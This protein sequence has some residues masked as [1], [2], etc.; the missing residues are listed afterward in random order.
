[1]DSD[2][3][4]GGVSAEP[5]GPPIAVEGDT[6]EGPPPGLPAAADADATSLDTADGAPS[7][8]SEKIDAA[9][10]ASAD[11][12]L[13]PP[14]V[15]WFAR[16][17]ADYVRSLEPPR[18]RILT[19]ATADDFPDGGYGWVV[20]AACFLNYT[21][22]MG[23]IYGYGVYAR[24]YYYD[25]VFPGANMFQISWAGSI[26]SATQFLVGPFA[27]S[28]ADRWGQRQTCLLGGAVLVAA[29]VLASFSTALWNLYLTQGFLYGVANGLVYFS[30]IT[31][32]QH[33]FSRKR[34]LAVGVAVA[35][36]GVGGFII[37]PMTQAMIDA[38][39]YAWALRI[40][41]IV[42]G[43]TTAVCALLLRPRF[44]VPKTKSK[45]FDIRYFKDF[46]FSLLYLARFPAAFGFF[47]PFTF[48]PSMAVNEGMTP[49]QGSLALGLVNAASAVGRIA[50]GQFADRCG[51]MNSYVVCQFL[52]PVVLLCVWPFATQFWS[53][54]VFSLVFGFLSG[55]YISLFPVVVAQ[56][57]GLK[58]LG[59][60]TGVL[61]TSTLPGHL[62]GAPIA[63][64]IVDATAQTGP[65]GTTTFN[66][67][68]LILYCGLVQ[69][70]GGIINVG[71]R[72]R[73]ADWKIKVRV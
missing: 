72:M 25:G 7:P 32:P 8:L 28:L 26:A 15:G 6:A 55:G 52:T 16:L 65:D 21:F 40:T 46:R 20:V 18:T 29:F 30:T 68:Y 24:T 1:M 22:C 69:L 13:E 17:R 43:G 39:G 71:L 10:P 66:Y 38:Y 56:C 64:L 48:I 42:G 27:G 12:P 45:F 61:F 37:S 36:G 54:I 35:G 5:D 50:M 4:G 14:P 41:G 11:P 3:L 34:G 62:A 60:I 31:A 9:E 33:W 63:G 44:E 49:Q 58:D 70:A 47:V 23:L 2:R 19:E 59:N 73:M 51:R 53:L 57:F 67:L